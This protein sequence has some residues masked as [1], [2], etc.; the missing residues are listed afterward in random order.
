M[1]PPWAALT[2]STAPTPDLGLELQERG[3]RPGG[4]RGGGSSLPAALASSSS[5][6]AAG[7]ASISPFPQDS[8]L[9]MLQQQQPVT[10]RSAFAGMSGCG[11]S[12]AGSR[13]LCEGSLGADGAVHGGEL[14]EQALEGQMH[15]G[16]RSKSM[17]SGVQAGARV[18]QQSACG[19]AA[20]TAVSPRRQGSLC[21]CL[22]KS[23]DTLLG[24]GL[25]WLSCA[26]CTILTV[27]LCP[28]LCC[29]V[30]CRA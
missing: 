7:S 18:D 17:V 19:A 1:L 16:R 11:L 2:S 6:Q 14:G 10:F 28:V 15:G 13:E 8:S 4:S 25:K 3:A 22:W 9:A 5:L 29:A 12:P 26:G 20:S 24:N 27:L 21:W 23:F 30:L